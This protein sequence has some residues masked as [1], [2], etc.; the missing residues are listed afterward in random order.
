LNNSLDDILGHCALDA[1]VSIIGPTAGY[2][3]DPLF[4]RGVDVVGGRVVKDGELFL[5]LLRQQKR[6]GKATQKIC[7]QKKTYGGIMNVE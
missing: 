7:F 1:W 6:W 5:Q 2:F 4:K 3:P